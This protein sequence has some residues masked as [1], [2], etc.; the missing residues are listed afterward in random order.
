MP[1]SGVCELF[2]VPGWLRAPLVRS[3]SWEIE[4]CEVILVKIIDLLE[5]F[6]D[7]ESGSNGDCCSVGE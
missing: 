5:R 3:V 1:L 4:R 2:F 7:I 6:G